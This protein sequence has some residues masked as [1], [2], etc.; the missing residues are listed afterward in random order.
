MSPPV[1]FSIEVCPM[2]LRKIYTLDHPVLRRKAK[3]ISRF[4]PYIERLV[5]DMFETMRAAPGVGLAAPQIGES[6]RVLV[7][8]YEDQSV[9][10][11]N[12]EIIKRGEEMLLGTEGCLSIP[13]V[14]G[15]DV[16]RHATVTVKARNPRGKEIRVNAEGWFA[17]I[18]QHEIDHL[19]GVLFIDRIPKEKVR[20]VEEDEVVQEA[21][22]ESTAPR[23]RGAKSARG[24]GM[25][26]KSGKGDG[27]SAGNVSSSGKNGKSSALTPEHNER[28]AP[29]RAKAAGAS[30]ASRGRTE[31][32]STSASAPGSP[33]PRGGEARPASPPSPAADDTTDTTGGA[34]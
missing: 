20:P 27:R 3:K 21:E 15:E 34:S 25:S 30:P 24:D 14:V 32:S 17:R 26:G 16:P 4:D 33:A 22:V 11:V 23:R 5:S 13:G 19:D 6:I 31:A 18:L 28:P 2:A 9:A 1:P 7:A 12:P 29:T 8:E 10:L